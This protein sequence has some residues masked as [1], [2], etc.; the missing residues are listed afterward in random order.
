[1]A[2]MDKKLI[3]TRLHPR[4]SFLMREYIFKHG[5]T[6][7]ALA[8]KVGMQRSHLNALLMGKETRPLSAY[9]LF[10]FIL[11]GVIMVTEIYD[12]APDSDREADFWDTAKES[13][14]IALLKRIARMRKKGY[15]IEKILDAVEVNP[16]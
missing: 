8:D 4:F 10:K 7:Q 13:E 9:Y 2:A 14:N 1:M 11:K 16:K 15:D 5:M 12:G 6:Q 3:L